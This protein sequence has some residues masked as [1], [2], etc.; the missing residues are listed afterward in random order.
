MDETFKAL[1]DLTRRQILHLLSQQD[2]QA[3]EIAEHFNMTK[4]SI[5]YH[6]NALKQAGLVVDQRRGQYIIYSLN[7]GVLQNVMR[8]FEE[9]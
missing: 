9:I 3:G 1:A 5:S 7:K 8:W 4:P 2:M 6:L